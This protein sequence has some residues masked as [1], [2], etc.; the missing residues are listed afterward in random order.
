MFGRRKCYSLTI[1]TS[2]EYILHSIVSVDS[3]MEPYK[4]YVLANRSKAAISRSP[5]DFVSFRPLAS[6]TFPF[7]VGPEQ[8]PI[9]I[10]IGL[11]QALSEPLDKLMNNGRMKESTEKVAVLEVDVETFLLFADFCYT[12]NYRVRPKAKPVEVVDGPNGT[13][14]QMAKQNPPEISLPT[15]YCFLCGNSWTSTMP[16]GPLY[17]SNCSIQKHSLV[18]V[19][20]GVRFHWTRA[21]RERHEPVCPTCREK[22]EVQRIICSRTILLFCGV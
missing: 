18:C 19:L 17:C 15:K 21:W 5:T 3:D 13:D 22:A 14:A 16:Q 6:R 4:S 11:L 10:H 9:D 1:A 7:L 12:S 2:I 8:K 20:C